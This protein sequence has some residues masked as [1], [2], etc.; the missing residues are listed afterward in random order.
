[1]S[2][3]TVIFRST[4]F[5]DLPERGSRKKPLGADL[6]AYLVTSLRGRGAQIDNP[7]VSARGGWRSMASFEGAQFVVILEVASLRDSKE[8][9]WLVRV[10]RHYGFWQTLL[11][12]GRT[13]EEAY[14]LCRELGAIL[15]DGDVFQSVEW[16]SRE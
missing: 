5:E 1:M 14:P 9:A 15:R 12:R 13:L 3:A 2:P 16:L 7:P 8:D 6:A 4:V 11:G 10:Q